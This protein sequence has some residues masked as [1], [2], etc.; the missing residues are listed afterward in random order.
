[1]P[2]RREGR[3]TVAHF[4]GNLWVMSRFVNMFRPLLQSASVISLSASVVF[5]QE[6]GCRELPQGMWSGVPFLQQL[7]RGRSW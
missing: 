1:M 2:L 3:A 6:D 5:Q 7:F 4:W